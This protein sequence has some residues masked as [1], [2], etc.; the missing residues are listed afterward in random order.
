MAATKW[1]REIFDR[2]D[3]N[4]GSDYIFIFVYNFWFQNTAFEYLKYTISRKL[5]FYLTKDLG[6]DHQKKSLF[7][8]LRFLHVL[9]SSLISMTSQLHIWDF[10]MMP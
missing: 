9:D 6:P 3:S 7:Q 5:I 1:T 10:Q 2:L 8:I 4:Q